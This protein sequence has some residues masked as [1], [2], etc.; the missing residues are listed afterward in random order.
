MCPDDV[1]LMWINYD[2]EPI[3]Y[4]TIPSG[5]THVQGTFVTH[6][7]ALQ[8]GDCA[9]MSEFDHVYFPAEQDETVTIV[10]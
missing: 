10:A 5:G 8:G 7:W 6:P 9:F 4:G 1:Q 2:G 3:S